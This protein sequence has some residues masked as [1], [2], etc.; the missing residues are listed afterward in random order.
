MEAESRQAKLTR[1]AAKANQ[2]RQRVL[3]TLLASGGGHLGGALSAMEVLTV[4]YFEVLRVDPANPRW[5]DRDRFVLS[6][7][8]A[9]CGLCP[10]LADRGFFADELLDT[11]NQLDSP[12]SMHPDMRKIPGVDMSTGS[13]GHGLAVAVG[14][15]LAA[16]V[17]EKGYRV[18][19]LLGDG[20]L[21]EGSVWEAAMAAAH[22]RLDQLTAIVDKNGLQVD[23]P[24]DEVM[25]TEPLADKW[26]SFGWAVREIDGHDVGQVLDALTAVPYVP[27]KPSLVIAHTVKGKG[28][29]FAENR[30]EWHYN[31]VNAEIVAQGLAELRAGEMG[32]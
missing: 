14:M 4:L 23:G 15:A 9:S 28:L 32:R 16:R 30:V 6:K 19:S 1:L 5:E 12:F 25:C 31:Y 20:E 13:L 11:F 10:I 21:C 26:R 24:T 17:E 18:F 3:T 2:M 7:G 22:F 29:S 8:H 27:G